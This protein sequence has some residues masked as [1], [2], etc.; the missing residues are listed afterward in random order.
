MNPSELDAL[1]LARSNNSL[2]GQRLV[3]NPR[4]APFVRLE[5]EIKRPR[6]MTIT[7]A[8]KMIVRGEC[9]ILNISC[10]ADTTVAIILDLLP[11][12]PIAHLQTE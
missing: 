11:L 12:T 6:Y 9:T 7:P 2:I 8:L 5:F 1:Y 10:H 4:T 3:S